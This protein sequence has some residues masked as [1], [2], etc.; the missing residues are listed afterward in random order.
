MRTEPCRDERTARREELFDAL[1]MLRDGAEGRARDRAWTTVYRYVRRV[2]PDD[3]AAD[4]R[5][6]ALVAILESVDELRA[7]SPGSAAGWVHSICR[8]RKIDAHRAACRRRA[9]PFDDTRTPAGNA[10]PATPAVE[11]APHVV[12]AF[13]ERVASHIVR[14]E[15]CPDVRARRRLQAAAT[16]YRTALDESLSEIAM[17]LDTHVSLEL[18]TKWVERGRTVVIET[19]EAER[20]RDPDLADL[21]APFAELAARRRVDAGILRPARRSRAS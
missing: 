11:L 14:T 7:A 17:R 4:A 1:A 16:L 19:I 2:L 13:L 20:A 3:R 21:F 15:G 6:D 9:A 18:L 12:A 5:Q 8:S 10:E